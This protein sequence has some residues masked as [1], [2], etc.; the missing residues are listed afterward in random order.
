MLL[1]Y[2][3]VRRNGSCSLLTCVQNL[4]HMFGPINNNCCYSGGATAVQQT[5]KS[6][7]N[8][9]CFFLSLVSNEVLFSLRIMSGWHR[10]EI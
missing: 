7:V 5:T 2:L 9:F 8:Y 1:F 3:L 4:V 6:F 10:F